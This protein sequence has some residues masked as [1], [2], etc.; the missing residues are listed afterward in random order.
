[1]DGPHE[2]LTTF[3]RRIDEALAF[4]LGVPQDLLQ[5]SDFSFFPQTAVIDVPLDL[6]NPGQ[7]ELAR[8]TGSRPQ[9]YPVLHCGP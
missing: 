2:E 3:R 5:A 8:S 1:M 7:V 4:F 6:Q 9:S